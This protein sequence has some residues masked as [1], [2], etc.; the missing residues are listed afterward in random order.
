MEAVDWKKR[1]LDSLREMETEERRW[2]AVESLLRKLVARLCATASGQDERLDAQLDKLAAAV[3]KDA[4]EPELKALLDSLTDAIR[5]LDQSVASTQTRALVPIA[6]PAE[7][8]PVLQEPAPAPAAPRWNATCAAV[9]ALLRHLD[10]AEPGGTAVAELQAA[11]VAA[12]DDAELAKVLARVAGLVAM[13]GE[14]LARERAA[15]AAMLAQVTERLGEMADYIASASADRLASREAADTLNTRVLSDVTGLADDFAATDDIEALRASV[16]H[17]LESVARQVREFHAREVERYAAASARADRMR[18]R[19]GELE[20]E[21]REL[22]RRLEAEKR[23]SRTDAV[24]RIPNRASFDE[25]LD[26]ELARWRRFRAPVSLLSWD[27]DHFKSV[28]DTYGHRAGDAALRKIAQCLATRK[29]ESDFLG[30]V[31]GEEFGLLL[32][33]TALAEA[34]RVGNELRDRIA[35]LGFHF[36][37][38]PL[39]ITAS[40]GI[41]EFR[42]GDTAESVVERADQALYAAKHGGRNR[43]VTA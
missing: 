6:P 20:T 41:T 43:C 12:G 30:R 10:T 37:G 29:R 35:A 36:R 19:I 16:A 11:V 25:R 39:T 27:V 28:N 15:A 23:R 33:G 22:H 2:R 42:D 32:V 24:T 4:G 18:L 7:A 17:R 21:T 34:E 3:K 5:A 26:A 31:G 13:R 38:T 9:R 8:V 40:C 1:Y 14:A